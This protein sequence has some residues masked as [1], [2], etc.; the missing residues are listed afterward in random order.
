M[1]MMDFNDGGYIIP[2][3]VPI[4]VGQ[5]PKVQGAVNQKTGNPWIE[6]YFRTLWFA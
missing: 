1:M 3:F 6:Y 4:I 5:S 2:V